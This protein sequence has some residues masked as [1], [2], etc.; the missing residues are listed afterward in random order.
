[1][2]DSCDWEEALALV[3][4]IEDEADDVPEAGEDFAAS[5]S[6]RASAIGDTIEERSH[7]TDAQMAALENMMSG[8]RKWTGR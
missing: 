1:M 5:V 2:C 3:G 8:L 7:V 6:D 4:E